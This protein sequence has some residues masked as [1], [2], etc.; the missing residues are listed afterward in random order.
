MQLWKVGEVKGF[1]LKTSEIPDATIVTDNDARPCTCIGRT[2][3]LG[4]SLSLSSIVSSKTAHMQL[5][6]IKIEMLLLPTE[7]F[8]SR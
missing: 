4:I 8:L 3:I 6:I 5:S 1:L 7:Y 2:A